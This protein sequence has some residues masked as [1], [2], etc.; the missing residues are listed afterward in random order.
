MNN[1]VSYH[2]GRHKITYY[3]SLFK[4]NSQWVP[5]G[6]SIPTKYTRK[7]LNRIVTTIQKHKWPPTNTKLI[8]I[9]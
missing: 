1:T 8:Y 7:E 4:H 6:T 9:P 3:I 5:Y 2:Q